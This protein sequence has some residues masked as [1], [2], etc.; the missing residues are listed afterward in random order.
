MVIWVT[1]KGYAGKTT[2]GEKLAS[3]IPNSLLIDA[4]D[5]R[6][7]FGGDFTDDGRRKNVLRMAKV[8]AIHEKQGKVPIVCCVSPTKA[9]REEARRM[10]KESVLICVPGGKLWEGTEYEEP[11]R[12]EIKDIA[13]N[14][15]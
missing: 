15:E 10:F 9:L 13:D 14:G 4:Y 12:S 2:T 3:I 8:A 6:R 11:D 1:G 7:Y 5:Y